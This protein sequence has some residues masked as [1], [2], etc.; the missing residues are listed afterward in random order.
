[1]IF[2][3]LPS[4]S[5][6]VA[7]FTCPCMNHILEFYLV[8]KLLCLNRCL[9]TKKV[10]KA[11]RKNFSMFKRLVIPL[12]FILLV[13][14]VSGCTSSQGGTEVPEDRSPACTPDWKC[15]EWS[16]CARSG[17][18]SRT[19]QDANNC[20]TEAGKPEESRPCTYA[21]KIGDKVNVDEFQYSVKEAFTLPVVGSEYLM[22]QAD[23]VFVI[24]VLDIENIGK[25]SEYL[26][27][28][29]FNLR[30]DKDRKYD[31]DISAGVYLETMG[32]ESLLFDKL[33]P[34]LSTEG[35]IVFDVPEDDTGL[36]LEISGGLLGG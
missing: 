1:M 24:L 20:G 27:S 8:F 9:N 32:Y 34:G 18:Q 6:L 11:L 33:G 12:L 28:A 4:V 7:S 23:G 14:A 10:F 16:E 26:S 19:C 17:T 25:E 21:A 29:R 35:S 30:D 3:F 13:L 22:E 36:K 5:Q 2:F 31:V 15:A